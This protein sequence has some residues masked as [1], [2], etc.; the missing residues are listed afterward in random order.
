MKG[1]I[2][3]ART[4]LSKALLG[5]FCLTVLS[6]V[7]PS[8]AQVSAPQLWKARALEAAGKLRSLD[9]KL[10]TLQDR[11][12]SDEANETKCEAILESAFALHIAQESLVHIISK[13][14]EHAFRII[15]DHNDNE[16][17]D[18]RRLD[19]DRRNADRRER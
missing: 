19:D 12:D 14:G 10:A 6:T 1:E 7:S 13:S 2:V 3:D 17:F 18:L 4:L 16:R 5:S 11:W 9:A 8:T 15:L